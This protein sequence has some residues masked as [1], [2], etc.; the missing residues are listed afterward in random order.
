MPSATV[1]KIYTSVV[2]IGAVANSY[3]FLAK[4]KVNSYSGEIERGKRHYFR[5]TAENQAQWSAQSIAI[6]IDVE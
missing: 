2:P 3:I 5:L 6:Y 4:Q 1:Y